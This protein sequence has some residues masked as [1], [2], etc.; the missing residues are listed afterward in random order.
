MKK[1][2]LIFSTLL[3]SSYVLGQVP[4]V[5]KNTKVD[6]FTG[7]INIEISSEI[8]SKKKAVPFNFTDKVNLF[9]FLN[10]YKEK[11]K[12]ETF[13]LTVVFYGSDCLSK[14]DGKME[15]LFEDGTSLDFAQISD[16][17]CGEK[18]KTP[19]YVLASRNFIEQ[20]TNEV[21]QSEISK[22]LIILGGKKITKIRIGGEVFTLK[23]EAKGMFIK[24]VEK[25][26]QSTSKN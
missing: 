18:F 26:Y 17:D 8:P 14:Y 19:R 23:D 15:L 2:S 4:V 7:A 22:N 1:L 10:S 20:N 6:E 16:T 21:L 9:I 5:N 24:Y 25:L 12:E 3:F 13:F 11:D